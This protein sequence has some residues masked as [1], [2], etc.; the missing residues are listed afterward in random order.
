MVSSAS[1]GEL[2]LLTYLVVGTLLC[3]KNT[4]ELFMSKIFLWKLDLPLLRRSPIKF[5][6][7]ERPK[8]S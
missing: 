1:E 4:S 7:C 5:L 3:M 8:S 2:A 6:D